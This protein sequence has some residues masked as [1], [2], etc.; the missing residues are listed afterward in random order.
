MTFKLF[1][2][3]TLL[4]FYS[5]YCLYIGKKFSK[6]ITSSDYFVSGKNLSF[7]LFLFAATAA[8][9]SGFTFLILP[10]LIFRDGF[11]A[12][13]ICFSAI[14]IPLA[15]TFFFKRQWI[16]SKHFN[17]TTPNEM[18]AD[19][20]QSKKIRVLITIITL[21][22][23]IPFLGLQLAAS[24]KLFNFLSN[25][26][27]D[28][29]LITWILAIVLL[30]YVVLG[31]L[32]SV[33][34][35]SILQFF[36]MF[37]G[38]IFMGFATLKLVGGWNIFNEN[39]ANL[40]VLEGTR[41]GKTPVDNYSAYF[42]IPDT[43]QL[44][45]GIDKEPTVGGIWTS[46][47]IFTY[48]LAFM[49]IQS[50]PAFSILVFSSKD[51]KPFATQQVWFSAFLVGMLLFFFSIITGMG[52]HFLGANQIV[53]NSTIEV[54]NLLPD[55]ISNGKEGSLV[56]YLINFFENISP[57][58]LSL[59]AICALA[60]LQSTGALFISTGSSILARDICNNFFK[61]KIKSEREISIAKNC[62]IIIVFLSL[63]L[64]S[65][66]ED[67]LILLGGVAIPIGFQMIVPLLA[68]CY[69]P[70][71]T[72]KGVVLGLSGGI[73][74]VLITDNIGQL[75]LRE[76]VPWGVW[77]LGIYS[78]FWGLL[79]NLSIA[80]FISIFTQEKKEYLHKKK[81]HN[82]LKKYSPLFKTKKSKI[83]FTNIFIVVVWL[84]F[85]LGPGARIGNSIFGDPGN[86]TTWLFGIPSIWAWQFLL[87][88]IGVGIMWSLA[89]KMKMSLKTN[90]KIYT[91]THEY[92]KF[93]R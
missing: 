65:F 53:N 75:F 57:W 10:G 73:L 41:W 40:S 52:A 4:F 68:I 62:S 12:A 1:S 32:K 49:G 25:D 70:W 48:V 38:V 47:M 78:A 13:Y 72:K 74:G 86:M 43:I 35:L 19:Y 77:P 91:N 82:F 24:G 18:F 42:A 31:G 81:Y 3:L 11:Q 34:Y 93:I 71:L 83:F 59:L 5:I 17:F 27:L 9:F 85:A 56:I 6:N 29:N 26:I 80:V 30:S 66:A 8:S 60:A 44:T 55:T 61:S 37:F 87:W 15:G 16:I 79:A 76:I 22:F 67:F 28:Q 45:L 14:L 58:I 54:I 21:F 88:I 46:A 90:N 63:L 7:S 39:L 2:I 84:F 23:S 64:I 33:A 92:K 36:L 69:I 89:Y 20:F 50:S 51:I